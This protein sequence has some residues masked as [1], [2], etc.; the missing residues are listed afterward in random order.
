MI[1]SH[2]SLITISDHQISSNWD[3]ATQNMRNFLLI[4][5]VE[6]VIS[7]VV[8]LGP[9]FTFPNSSGSLLGS[10]KVCGRSLNISCAPTDTAERK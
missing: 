3:C 2:V 8:N 9:K 4:Y 5:S 6:F 1:Q 10:T 7:V